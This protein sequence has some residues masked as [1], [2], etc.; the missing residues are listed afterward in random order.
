MTSK[1]TPAL[2]PQPNEEK[3]KPPTI[4]KSY[5]VSF[6]HDWC[7]ECG[8][9]IAF[10]QKQIIQAAQNGKPEITDAERCIGCRYCEMHCPD[11]AITVVRKT[12]QR[13]KTD[14]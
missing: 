6:Y 2:A 14:E 4:K 9:C 12:P 7:K 13:R 1:K 8:L 5:T 11:F 3:S 10:C